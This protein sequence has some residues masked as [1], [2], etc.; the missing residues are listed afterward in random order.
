MVSSDTVDGFSLRL[1]C[2]HR[3][4]GELKPLENGDR[5][6]NYTRRRSTKLILSHHFG[7]KIETFFL[8]QA[9]TV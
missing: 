1:A 3:P 5:R 9:D 7:G 2:S 4:M 6:E 8:V